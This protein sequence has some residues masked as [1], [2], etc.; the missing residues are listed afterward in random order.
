M[1]RLS[2]LDT[3]LALTIATGIVSSS[4]LLLYDF[5][6]R[7]ILNILSIEGGV[8]AAL[9]IAWVS[10][11]YLV[12][13]IVGLLLIREKY[14]SAVVLEIVGAFQLLTGTALYVYWV[15]V[16]PGMMSGLIFISCPV[17]LLVVVM[18]LLGFA[19]MLKL[20]RRQSRRD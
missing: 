3:T 8:S 14:V 17:I 6:R 15:F 2:K 1:R 9:W 12:F 20:A 16:Q 7:N 19:T 11:P 18:G 5:E 10:L 4:G 13:G